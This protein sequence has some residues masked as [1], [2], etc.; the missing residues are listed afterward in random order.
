MAETNVN[1]MQPI[2]PAGGVAPKMFARSSQ[3]PAAGV[4]TP[5]SY[6]LAD[7]MISVLKEAS[8][9]MARAA[10]KS[11]LIPLSIMG[12]ASSEDGDPSVDQFGGLPESPDACNGGDG[13]CPDVECPTCD[14][15]ADC[16]STE[17]PTCDGDSDCSECEPCGE[18]ECPETECPECVDGDI[19]DIDGD[20]EDIDGDTADGDDV[21][22]IEDDEI[23]GIEDGDIDDIDGEDGDGDIDGIEDGDID[24]IDGDD[25]D[26]D[27]DGIED[28][29]A[30]TEE[31]VLEGERYSCTMHAEDGFGWRYAM[32]TL[33]LGVMEETDTGWTGVMRFVERGGDEV[34]CGETPDDLG[35]RRWT[36]PADTWSLRGVDVRGEVA[37]LTGRWETTIDLT[38]GAEQIALRGIEMYLDEG[39]SA[40]RAVDDAIVFPMTWADLHDLPETIAGDTRNEIAVSALGNIVLPI[41]CSMEDDCGSFNGALRVATPGW[42]ASVDP[43]YITSLEIACQREEGGN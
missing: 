24:D 43:T 16:P 8:F 4:K 6:A 27:I 28:G 37:D 36:E 17:C 7:R 15:D 32:Q 33:T 10:V 39:E 21:D 19:D 40:Y 29:D 14:G 38:I 18:G 11:L 9:C 13:E 22:G 34:D 26:G 1:R 41:A 12:C 5:D 23:D 42:P 25:V 35:C 31:E 2:Q 3:T 20:I 30:E